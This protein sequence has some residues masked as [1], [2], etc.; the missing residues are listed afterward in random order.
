MLPPAAYAHGTPAPH[1]SSPEVLPRDSQ[2]PL[3]SAS[4]TK[5]IPEAQEIPST[6][7][8]L[9]FCFFCFYCPFLFSIYLFFSTSSPFPHLV[10]WGVS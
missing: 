10:L 9:I 4:T 2:G 5:S 8:L 3:V 6:P 1:A 7:I